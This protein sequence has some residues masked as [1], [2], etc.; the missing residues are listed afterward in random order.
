MREVSET[1]SSLVFA[2]ALSLLLSP[3][4][5]FS[6]T[7]P[8]HTHTQSIAK[9][10]RWLPRLIAVE[11]LNPRVRELP[12]THVRVKNNTHM[13]I[14]SRSGSVWGKARET[15]GFP[16]EPSFLRRY[17]IQLF[18]PSIRV[19]GAAV[20]C[21]RDLVTH[22]VRSRKI[23]RRT[24]FIGHKRTR[25]SRYRSGRASPNVSRWSV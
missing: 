17:Y 21:D 10:T 7:V 9:L 13:C 11:Y 15:L 16:Q 2:P 19:T 12:R 14:R 3:C 6:Y 24:E 18:N 1:G 4:K 8:T 20:R 25:R 5:N 22:R 23:K